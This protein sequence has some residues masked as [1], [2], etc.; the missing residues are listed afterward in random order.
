MTKS[1]S[2]RSTEKNA[3]ITPMSTLSSQPYKGTRDYYPADK[4]VQN[5]I[6]NNWRR[7]A[8]RFGYEEY[9]A[10]M[11]EPIDVYEAKSGQELANEQ[12]YTFTDR[13]DR[14]VAIRPEMTPSISRMVAAKRQELAYPARLFSIANFMRY[15]RPQR[16]REREF[17]QLN[18]DI[19]GV[20]GALPEAEIITMGAEFLKVFGA[21]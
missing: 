1:S 5:Y 4:R 12:T 19:F 9:G 13:G 18:T 20:E 6:F 8:Q 3:T 10:P 2:L 17:W 7:I 15:E 14:T 16:G 21:T 11:L